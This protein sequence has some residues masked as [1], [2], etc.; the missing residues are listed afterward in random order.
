[1]IFVARLGLTW[2]SAFYGQGKALRDQ[3]WQNIGKDIERRLACGDLDFNL[4]F[5]SFS[6][7]PLTAEGWRVVEAVLI[8]MEAVPI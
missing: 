2:L 8:L 7:R 1:M 6:G 4:H 5:L 3:S